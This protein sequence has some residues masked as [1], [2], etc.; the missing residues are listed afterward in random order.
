MIMPG[1]SDPDSYGKFLV[2]QTEDG[3]FLGDDNFFATYR[4]I[5]KA[6]GCDT[7]VI[8]QPGGSLMIIAEDTSIASSL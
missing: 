2:L 1:V 6:L 5:A 3:Q 7:K 8:L 4:D